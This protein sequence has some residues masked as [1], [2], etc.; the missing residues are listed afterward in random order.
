MKE[1][2]QKLSK[3]IDVKSM[4]TLLFTALVYKLAM[5]GIISGEQ[6]MM[7]YTTIIAFYFGTQSQKNKGVTSNDIT[8]KQS[9]DN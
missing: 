5:K 2:W 7:T 8:I 1:L 9:E 6:V 3:L 4:I